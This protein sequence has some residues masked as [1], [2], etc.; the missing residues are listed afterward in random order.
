MTVRAAMS[1]HAGVHVDGAEPAA[2]LVRAV[3]DAGIAIAD[4]TAWDDAFFAAFLARVEPA[5]AA[6]ALVAMLERMNYYVLSKQVHVSRE[7]MVDTL[8]NVMHAALVA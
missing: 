6:L 5:I 1:E 2:D 4:G 8:T 7:A 3:R